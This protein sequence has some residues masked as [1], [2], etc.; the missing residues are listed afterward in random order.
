VNGVVTE[1]SRERAQRTGWTLI[2]L[3]AATLALAACSGDR[4]F[5]DHQTLMGGDTTA[6]IASTTTA[7][8]NVS[9]AAQREHQR[10]LAAYGGAYE[11]TRLEGEVSGTV[12]RL[13]AASER[14]DIT[15][16]VTILNS[17]AVNA[18]ALPTGQLYVTR[19]LLA[20]ANDNAELASVLSHEMAHVIARHAAI[21][22]EEAR[23]VSINSE[24]VNG[25]LS[26]P[27]DGAL[28]L[29]RSKIKFATFSR[30]QEFEADGIGVGIAAHAG[31][32]P[33]GASRFLTSMGRNADLRAGG[34][35]SDARSPDFF[36]SHPA[37][38]ERV[39]NA[40]TTARQYSAPNAGDRGR[41]GYLQNL[42]GLVYGE[43][44]IEGY[45]RGRRFLH[46]KLGFTFTA[47]EGFT[48]ENTAQAVLGLRDG[49]N[50]ALRLDA[51]KVPAEQSLTAYLGSGW[52]ENVEPGSIEEVTLGGLPGATAAARGDQWSFRLYVVR[53][54][55]EVYRFIFAA[56]T[57]TPE[58]E[59]AFRDSVATFRRLSATEAQQAKPLR[60][61]IVT[62]RPGDTIE[63]LASRMAL[64]DRQAERF[65][66]L[67]GLEPGERL[68]AGDQVKIVVE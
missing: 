29:A 16:K 41:N 26:D 25:V 51:V 27:Q 2:C 42:D 56:K 34:N 65:R 40:Q 62:V 20:L 50:E 1:G 55:G 36:S 61:K 9:P 23:Q 6:S 11:D 3:I 43:D 33:F 54:N 5:G 15:Y 49:G 28:A 4:I 68:K 59:R 12:N 19:G 14:P 45:V 37:T 48:L 32:D 18:F 35:G 57:R 46:P 17:P 22:E 39:K 44:P 67:N 60:L 47:P 24:V 63:R 30:S 31:Y 53:F 13:V 38:P 7:E 21:R 52:I 58:I 10:I 64:I 8:S 66:V